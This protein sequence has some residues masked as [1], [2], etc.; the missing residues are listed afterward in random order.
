VLL[1]TGVEHWKPNYKED[2]RS[3]MTGKMTR[4]RRPEWSYNR[5]AFRSN[6]PTEKSEYRTLYG[7][8]GSNPNQLMGVEKPV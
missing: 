3:T 2:N 5:A 8:R 4:A 1:A 6:C 7:E